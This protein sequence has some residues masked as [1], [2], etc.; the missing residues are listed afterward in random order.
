MAAPAPLT[1][2]HSQGDRRGPR[3]LRIIDATARNV[4]PISLSA[5]A[6]RA[7][8]LRVSL[9]RSTRYEVWGETTRMRLHV[10]PVDKIVQGMWKSCHTP[11]PILYEF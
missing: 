6:Y 10:Y 5:V 4:E 7:G 9:C 8:D 1:L 11:L 2:S 3:R